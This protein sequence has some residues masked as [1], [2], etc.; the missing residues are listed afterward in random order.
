MRTVNT[1]PASSVDQPVPPEVPVVVGPNDV[2]T[3]DAALP[4][5]TITFLLTDIQD[6]T[7]LWDTFP[8]EMRSTTARHDRMI[9]SI[10][11]RHAGVLVR[12]RGEGDSRFAVFR[13]ATAA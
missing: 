12:P 4:T 3:A 11:E 2:L 10:V 13:R 9:E 5:G 6:S 1:P 7:R 8:R